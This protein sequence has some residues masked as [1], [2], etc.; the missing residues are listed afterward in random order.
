MSV[1]PVLTLGLGD[2]TGGGVKYL[3]T[4]GYG[5][6]GTP[7]PVPVIVTTRPAGVK[8]GQGKRRFKLGDEDTAEFLKSQLRLRHPESAPAPAEPAQAVLPKLS[9]AERKARESLAAETARA[10]A[11]EQDEQTRKV[12]TARNNAILTLLLLANQ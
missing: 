6:G 3:P 8:R 10:M 7:P 2:F 4:L 5:T 12:L 1:G 9:K 11:I